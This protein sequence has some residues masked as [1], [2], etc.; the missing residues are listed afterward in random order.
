MGV[1][2]RGGNV[3]A[4]AAV[5]CHSYLLNLVP[6]DAGRDC[7]HVLAIPL[8]TMATEHSLCFLAWQG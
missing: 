4:V 2:G 6:G 1:S 3:Y 7:L 8:Y 5:A